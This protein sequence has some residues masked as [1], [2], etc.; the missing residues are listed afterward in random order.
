VKKNFKYL[1][2]ILFVLIITFNSCTTEEN[3][4]MNDEIKVTSINTISNKIAIQN[5][6]QNRKEYTDL[7]RN[8]YK[9]SIEEYKLDRF[10]KSNV[11][12]DE[13][14]NS[15]K[16]DYEACSECDQ[17][18]KQFLLKM[19]EE[20]LI[21]ENESVISIITKYSKNIE[22]LEIGEVRKDNLRFTL[23]SFE[24]GAK[25]YLSLAHQKGF[26]DCIASS[27]GKNIG[28]GL[29][30]GFLG[31]CAVGGYVGATV[32]TVTVPVIGTVVG[33]AAGCIAAGAVSGTIGAAFGAFWTVA[34]CV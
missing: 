28:R 21:S 23:F 33:G 32:G 27:A 5:I 31:G 14:L 26:W 10:R 4:I 29:V 6:L 15:L 13:L 11:S 7:Y 30:G 18:E 25:T 34:D 1:Q 20:L 3:Q 24:E 12:E 19:F 16:S 2:F 17:E 8:Q 9:Q 22:N